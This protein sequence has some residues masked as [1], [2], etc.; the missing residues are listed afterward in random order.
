MV[1]S[2]FGTN[3]SE[4]FLLGFENLADVAGL[5]QA[6]FFG[7]VVEGLGHWKFFAIGA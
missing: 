7:G 3:F 1:H 6:P 4:F 2:C 5:G